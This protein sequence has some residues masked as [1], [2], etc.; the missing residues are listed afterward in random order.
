MKNKNTVIVTGG[1]GFIGSNLIDLLLKKN[2]YVINL[3]K[4]SYSSNF[5][6]TKNFKSNNNYK[7][8]K[9]DILNKRKIINILQKEKPKAIFPPVNLPYHIKPTKHPHY[10]ISN[11]GIA[12]REPRQCD[13]TGVYGEV[14]EWGLIQ[15]NTQLRGNPNCGEEYM[16]EGTNIYLY[17]ENDKN[18]GVKKRNI[19]QLV[20]ETWIPNPHGYTEVLHG[21][22]GNRCNHYTNLRWGTHKEN[23]EEA[24]STLPEGTR[25]R[26]KGEK[27]SL[28]EKKDG[29]WVLV[30]KLDKESGKFIPWNKGKTYKMP[31]THKAWNVLPDGTVRIRNDKKYIKHDG[32]WVYQK[33]DKKDR[34]PRKPKKGY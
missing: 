32:I 18:I 13:R 24:S 12:Y 2:F 6:N 22:K 33:K 34:K 5:Y 11:D 7:F 27:G 25:R 20:A 19:H 10:Y 14:N 9:C 16:Y 4:I 31:E 28:Y 23:M 1:L 30:P 15:L 21:E 8:I 26:I 29:K 3:D 17:D